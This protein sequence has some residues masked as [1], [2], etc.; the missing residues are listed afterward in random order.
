MNTLNSPLTDAVDYFV[1]LASPTTKLFC[2]CCNI[3]WSGYLHA[4][5][6]IFVI[7]CSMLRVDLRYCATCV[8]AVDALNMYTKACM[9]DPLVNSTFS[10]A[11]ELCCT[12]WRRGYIV[13][14]AQSCI[15]T[16]Y[17]SQFVRLSYSRT[18]IQTFVRS[19]HP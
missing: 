10:H 7:V 18:I 13:G 6:A 2:C 8:L 19:F 12:S 16:T 9:D 17:T 1:H 4:T 14:T 15:C 5:C 11:I 3:H